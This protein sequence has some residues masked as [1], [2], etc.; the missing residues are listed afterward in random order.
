MRRQHHLRPL[1]DLCPLPSV[2]TASQ[3]EQDDRNASERTVLRFGG[4]GFAEGVD[5]AGLRCGAVLTRLE[6]ADTLE[7]LAARRAS[8]FFGDAPGT[9]ALASDWRVDGDDVTADETDE[10]DVNDVTDVALASDWRID[11]A[12]TAAPESI[13]RNGRYIAV[14]SP[15]RSAP[16]SHP[17]RLTRRWHVAR[18][19]GDVT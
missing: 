17:N 14:T 16:E 2:T 15:L 1:P 12:V 5:T 19:C 3:P 10:T 4:L 8:G 13:A 11:G 6:L 9:E 18:P 7:W